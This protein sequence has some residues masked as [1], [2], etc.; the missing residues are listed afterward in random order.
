MA[1]ADSRWSAT[2]HP[3]VCGERSSQPTQRTLM[4]GSSPRVRGTHHHVRLID[5]FHQV[6]PRVC[7][8]RPGIPTRARSRLCGSSPRVR[9]TPVLQPAVGAR[10]PGS[11]PRVRGTRA[12]RRRP[13]VGRRFIPACAG[14]SIPGLV[15]YGVR[16]VHPRV[17]GELIDDQRAVLDRTGS[18]PRVRGTPERVGRWVLDVRFIPACAGNSTVACLL[19][20]A[21]SVHPRV[22]GELGRPG[23]QHHLADRFIPACAGNS[24]SWCV[25]TMCMAVHPRVCGELRGNSRS[26]HYNTGSSP[27]VRG[28]PLPPFY[29]LR[30]SR[31]I[32]ACAGNS[33][34]P[35]VRQPQ[36]TV[37]P[38]VCGELVRL[39]CI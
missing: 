36:A 33:R 4:T 6:H 10:R 35:Q 24:W 3:R 1:L 29:R 18:S 38:R 12:A 11:S 16:P 14:N 13:V 37:H 26:D 17:C 30:C 39:V 22:C 20:T 5:V 25:R 8:E 27:R 9:G 23:S 19:R 2:V 28:T 15:S 32:P 31:F 21:A 7:G 34:Q